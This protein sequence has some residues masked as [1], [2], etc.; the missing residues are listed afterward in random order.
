MARKR[1]I[2]PLAQL[3]ASVLARET[4]EIPWGLLR[5][6]Y[7]SGKWDRAALRHLSAWADKYGIAVSIEERNARRDAW[8]RFRVPVADRRGL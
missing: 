7:F 3:A 6:A 1:R 8:V 2:D 4:T 5:H